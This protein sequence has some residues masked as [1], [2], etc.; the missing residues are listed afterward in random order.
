MNV[1]FDPPN[2]RPNYPRATK[3]PTSSEAAEGPDV[4]IRTVSL[5]AANL[6]K[7]WPK[8]RLL[9]LCGGLLPG[10]TTLLVIKS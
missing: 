3:Q 5:E 9:I 8:M 2:A 6:S 7:S 10:S 4:D 1:D